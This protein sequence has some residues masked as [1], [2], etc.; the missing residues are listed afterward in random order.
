MFTKLQCHTTAVL[1]DTLTSPTDLTDATLLSV[2]NYTLND[3]AARA[4][5]ISGIESKFYSLAKLKLIVYTSIFCVTIDAV[6]GKTEVFSFMLL[7]PMSE[8][9][10]FL[11]RYSF[12]EM[13]L[14][15]LLQDF[16]ITPLTDSFVS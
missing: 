8:T 7:L 5:S 3:E 9:S 10:E 11:A 14:Q 4:E 15:K 13:S 2:A 1:E 12:C 6:K 16:L